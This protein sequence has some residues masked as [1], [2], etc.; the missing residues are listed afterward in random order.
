M[1]ENFLHN[2]FQPSA[3][4]ANQVVERLSSEIGFL[5]S[6]LINSGEDYT[7]KIFVEKLQLLREKL[8]EREKFE[9]ISEEETDEPV[10]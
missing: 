4:T 2:F 1:P 8:E 5:Y 7:S 9:R 6:W 3:L 10:N